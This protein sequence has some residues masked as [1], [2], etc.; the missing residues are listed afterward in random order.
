M[1]EYGAAVR[2]TWSLLNDVR[3]RPGHHT[4]ARVQLG[5][6]L[7]CKGPQPVQAC[8]AAARLAAGTS[9]SAL[10]QKLAY[11]QTFLL[12]PLQVNCKEHHVHKALDDISRPSAPDLRLGR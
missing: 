9:V 7:G 1:S 4:A 2:L 12:I 11:E 6:L 5:W 3:L 8:T 10:R